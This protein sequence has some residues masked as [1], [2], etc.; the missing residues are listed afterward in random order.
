MSEHSRWRATNRRASRDDVDDERFSDLPEDENWMDTLRGELEGDD[1][2]GPGRLFSSSPWFD[3]QQ[4]LESQQVMIQTLVE[5]VDDLQM[6]VG[7]IS[8]D[9]AD[10]AADLRAPAPAETLTAGTPRTIRDLVS[11]LGLKAAQA[12]SRR[13]RE[14]I[15]QNPSS[16]T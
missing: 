16:S 14:S 9:I 6:V 2:P 7:R 1:S 4:V 5:S 3:M 13:V 10:L 12:T 15:R 11:A 8:A